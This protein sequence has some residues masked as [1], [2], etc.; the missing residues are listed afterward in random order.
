[1]I[2]AIIMDGLMKWMTIAA[3]SSVHEKDM[4]TKC[5]KIRRISVYAPNHQRITFMNVKSIVLTVIA[6]NRLKVADDDENHLAA[7]R[8]AAILIIVSVIRRPIGNVRCERPI[9][10]NDPMKMITNKIPMVIQV[11]IVCHL[12]K[13]E[14]YKGDQ[15]KAAD[16]PHGMVTV[17]S[18][19]YDTNCICMNIEL[20][21]FITADM[22]PAGQRSWKRPASASESER[23][24]AENRRMNSAISGSDGEKDR[25]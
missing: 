7:V 14:V 17:S 23:K 10:I 13:H 4:L 2:S 15:E 6:P 12:L 5:M 18:L 19:L 22:N 11:C 20:Y 24:L 21:F 9:K 1:M 25:R 3:M 8:C 16:H